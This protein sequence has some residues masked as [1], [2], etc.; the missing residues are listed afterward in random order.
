MQMTGK[1]SVTLRALALVLALVMLITLCQPLT[2]KAQAYDMGD[3]KET[4][5]GA[6]V[7]TEG[8]TYL[9]KDMASAN[10]TAGLIR[11]ETALRKTRT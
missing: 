11:V 5:T 3:I 1:I 6:K 4:I 10:T 2:P 8:G 7:I 9:V